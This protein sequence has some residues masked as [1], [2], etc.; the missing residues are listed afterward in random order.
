MA[1]QG[2]R[3]LDLEDM[4]EDGEATG[5]R[6]GEGRG[7]KRKRGFSEAGWKPVSP[8]ER[9]RRTEK[10]KE[11]TGRQAG[12][13]TKK[14]EG[15]EKAG[16]EEEKGGRGVEDEKKERQQRQRK[17]GRKR[18]G[19]RTGREKGRCEDRRRKEEETRRKGAE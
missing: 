8:D 5:G 2:R 1:P 7:D 6:P 14:E 13:W 18:R 11:K 16:A 10:G 4:G 3:P 17:E 19:V 15:E 9:D 12:G